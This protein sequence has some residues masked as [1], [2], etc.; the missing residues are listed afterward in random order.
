MSDIDRKIVETIVTSGGSVS[1]FELMSLLGN[2]PDS[3]IDAAIKRLENENLVK[4]TRSREEADPLV[5][6]REKELERFVA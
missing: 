4:I 5:T 6:I 1:R 3:E 2:L